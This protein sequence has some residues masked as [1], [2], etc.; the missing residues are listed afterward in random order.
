MD[1][2]NGESWLAC[3]GRSLRYPHQ[4][5]A[6]LC[7]VPRME[8]ILEQLRRVVLETGTVAYNMFL[9]V[10]AR[11]P[12]TVK[13]GKTQ[14]RFLGLLVLDSYFTWRASLVVE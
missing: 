14:C 9:S 12:G 6:K 8:R 7:E 4:R 3:N 11:C 1:G 13:V 2:E 5:L 10:C